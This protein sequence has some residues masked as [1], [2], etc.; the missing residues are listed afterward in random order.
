MQEDLED[1]SD[2]RDLRGAKLDPMNQLGRSFEDA[3]K[4]LG[5]KKKKV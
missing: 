1:Y 4:K 5:L 2:L 3:A